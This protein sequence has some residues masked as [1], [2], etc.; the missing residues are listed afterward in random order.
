MVRTGKG[1][2]LSTFEAFGEESNGLYPLSY[3]EEAV[4]RDG[5]M[6]GNAESFRPNQGGRGFFCF[7]GNTR[8]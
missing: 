3:N 8:R 6:G 5:N 2:G 7:I 1:L 4:L